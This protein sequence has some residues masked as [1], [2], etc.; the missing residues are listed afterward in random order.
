MHKSV[1]VKHEY[2]SWCQLAKAWA[3]SVLCLNW[4]EVEIIHLTLLIWRCCSVHF[5][6]SLSLTM[7]FIQFFLS[8]IRTW[9]WT[10]ELRNTILMMPT[11]CGPGVVG[12]RSVFWGRISQ[13][14]M[15]RPLKSYTNVLQSSWHFVPEGGFLIASAEQLVWVKSSNMY[16]HTQA[17]ISFLKMC[18]AEACLLSVYVTTT[19]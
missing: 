19:Y 4:Q 12:I 13:V 16:T 2:N 8:R 1:I 14:N 10:E 11:V 3:T 5:K 9:L 18:A 17:V 15:T 6:A 7:Q